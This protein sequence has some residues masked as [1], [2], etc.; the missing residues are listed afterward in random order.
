M[1]ATSTSKRVWPGI[2]LVT[3]LLLSTF[4]LACTEKPSESACKALLEHIID[5]E[6]AE[7]G[8][9]RLSPAMK[10]DLDKQRTEL[11]KYLGKNF[12]ASCQSDLPVSVVE[13]RMKAKTRAA[14]AACEE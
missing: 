9:K 4:M 2:G 6:I 13:C 14:I 12:V 1:H 7:A 11:R 8:T 10:K 5:V 3:V